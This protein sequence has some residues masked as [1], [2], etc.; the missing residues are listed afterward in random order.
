D[1]LIEEKNELLLG[2]ELVGRKFPLLI[3]FL[4]PSKKLSVQ[5]HPNDEYAAKHENGEL[6]K[7]EAWYIV[8]AEEDAYIVLG[9]NGCTKDEF[10]KSIEDGTIEEYMNKIK[11]KKGDVFYLKSGLIHTMGP[12]VIVAEIQQN[13]DTTYRVYDYGR[14]RETH[15]E[16][17]LDVIRF[18][19]EGRL[20]EGLLVKKEGYNKTY[21]CLSKHFSLEVY[22]IFDSVTEISDENRFYIFTT[23]EGEG[24]INYNKG[25]VSF[26][27]GDSIFIPATLG[28]Y[29]IQGDCKL[30]KSYVPDVEAVKKEILNIII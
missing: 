11:V 30:I 16:K 24:I 15:I 5:V 28:K 21:Y 29:T 22:D 25:E 9:T 10:K 18:D 2:K 14:G 17:A 13:S 3:K 8:E 4:S 12:G 7:T 26:T 27:K 1:E 6:G 23:V 19:Y 20:R